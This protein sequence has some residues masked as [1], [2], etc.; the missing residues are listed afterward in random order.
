[1]SDGR[2]A[3]VLVCPVHLDLQFNIKHGVFAR[4]GGGRGTVALR[5]GMLGQS[6]SRAME[7]R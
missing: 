6:S 5:Q 4:K 1:V 3:D 7:A 2:A